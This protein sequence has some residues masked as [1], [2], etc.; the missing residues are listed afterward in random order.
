MDKLIAEL[1]LASL[2]WPELLLRVGLAACFGLMIGY[3]R[4][5]KNKPVDFR[6][7]VIV[8]VATTI[9]AILGQELYVEYASAETVVSIDLAKIIS[10]VMTGIGFLGAGAIIKRDDD[11]VVGTATGASIWASGGI[12]LTIGF[13][14]YGL[15]LI[16]FAVILVILLLGGVLN[17]R[18]YVKTKEEPVSG[19]H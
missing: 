16:T 3:D 1:A 13:G 12:G 10:G 14:A 5:R 19:Q 17:V 7:Y 8:S 6:V 11:K 15:A 18:Q 2:T 9:L 4:N